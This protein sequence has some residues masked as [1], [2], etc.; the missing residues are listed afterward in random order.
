MS[1]S[2]SSVGRLA[3]LNT[4]GMLT[5]YGAT[6][7]LS[8]YTSDINQ[9]SFSTENN[10]TKA[11]SW[12]EPNP[13]S[14]PLV[15]YTSGVQYDPY[16]DTFI[17]NEGTSIVEIDYKTNKKINSISVSNLSGYDQQNAILIGIGGES[18][19]Y[20]LIKGT[21]EL[22]KISRNFVG[23]PTLI[24][25]I[26]KGSYIATWALGGFFHHENLYVLNGLGNL[27]EISIP[28]PLTTRTIFTGVTGQ[29]FLFPLLTYH[30]EQVL[31]GKVYFTLCDFKGANY[32]IFKMDL[33][34]A[35]NQPVPLSYKGTK[36]APYANGSNE[37]SFSWTFTDADP[38]DQATAY[39]VIIQDGNTGAVI[40]DTGKVFSRSLRYFYKGPALSWNRLYCW[41]VKVWDENQLESLWSI[42][43]YF[44]PNQQPKIYDLTGSHYYDQVTV[45]LTPRLSFKVVDQDTYPI[46]GFYISIKETS[47][48]PRDVL[49]YRFIETANPWYDVPEGLLQADCIYSWEAVAK[50]RFGV[51]SNLQSAYFRTTSRLSAPF[52]LSPPNGIRTGP[53]PSFQASIV[54]DPI[55]DH[56]HF[57]LQLASDESY[58]GI[59]ATYSTQDDPAG[60]EVFDGEE[61]HSFP[62][63]G[64]RRQRQLVQNADFAIHG[65]SATSIP[66]WSPQNHWSYEDRL[67]VIDL[68]EGTKALRVVNGS[69]RND[70][71]MR[72]L[73]KGWKAGD[74]LK[75]TLDAHMIRFGSAAVLKVLMQSTDGM[76]LNETVL[77]LTE[78]SEQFQTYVAELVLPDGQSLDVLYL[79]IRFDGNQTTGSECLIRSI[80]A[81]VLYVVGY[82]EVRF[83]PI[84]PLPADRYWWRMNAISNEQGTISDSTEQ[85]RLQ[86]YFI[87]SSDTSKDP[88]GSWHF[89]LDASSYQYD[90]D[91]ELYPDAYPDGSYIIEA[92]AASPD[93]QLQLTKYFTGEAGKYYLVM[94]KV[95]SNY[96]D[97]PL[98]INTLKGPSTTQINTWQTLHMKIQGGGNLLEFT[99]PA[100]QTASD[101][102]T[103]LSQIC[104]YEISQ[105]EF[106]RI[107]VDPGWSG[108]NLLLR[109][110]HIQ[111]TVNLAQAR[112]VSTSDELS[113]HLKT[114]VQTSQAAHYLTLNAVWKH[115]SAESRRMSVPFDMGQVIYESAGGEWMTVS[116]A[117]TITTGMGSVHLPFRGTGI[118]WHGK[119]TPHSFIA[120][121]LIDDVFLAEIDQFAESEEDAVLFE[122]ADLPYGS[123]SITILTTQLANPRCE[124]PVYR[125]HIRS[126]DI[127]LDEPPATIALVA[128]NN[129]YDQKP[130]WEDLTHS[131]L[132]STAHTFAN[133]RKTASKWGINVRMV[134]SATGTYSPVEVDGFG[135]SFE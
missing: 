15:P 90:Y 23:S 18:F 127:L 62:M 122:K 115:P 133:K 109:Y 92:R 125:T 1:I 70:W 25:S 49:T 112:S 36:E 97:I 94:I 132:H 77:S 58:S 131:L 76:R 41:R 86:N 80:T 103:R 5:L 88:M 43:Q 75:I 48:T 4:K 71:G 26:P 69:G 28:N 129:G 89:G 2:G 78:R 114:P 117:K 12:S 44:I 21:G 29:S 11:Q 47:P 118:R 101:Q 93:T 82:Q 79:Y 53:S 39:Q 107:D 19:F 10:L 104:I 105:A 51:V 85:R 110:P 113:F 106:E 17:R 108:D 120:Y 8:Y 98:M 50:D 84:T 32:Q 30:P 37:P 72:Q 119:K 67:E 74:K 100:L 40:H 61:W 116:D 56:Q 64:V 83:T 38:G 35:P 57:R 66:C 128:C 33:G 81:E 46:Q 130:T 55:G 96:P 121:V 22:Y 124:Q 45:G 52:L 60:W 95:M 3:A 135:F 27:V 123:H 63:G 31:Y 6:R 87:V 59:V 20:Y 24:G 73:L 134:I 102:V 14:F 68:T 91:I 16:T 7:K 126:F 9:T 54:H 99:I 42:D 13:T 34:K 111:G 65:D